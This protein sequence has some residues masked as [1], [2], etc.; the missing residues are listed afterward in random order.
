MTSRW[1]PTLSSDRLLLR[2]IA[3][4]DFEPLFKAASDPLIWEQHSEKTRF[5]R[6][7][8][9]KFFQGALE[10]GGGLVAI[11]PKSGR[12]IGSSRY[13]DWNKADE[14]VVIGYSFLERAQWG[15]GINAEMKRLMLTHAFQWAKTVW[16]HVSPENKRSQLALGKIGATLDRQEDVLVGGVMSPRMIYRVDGKS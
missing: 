9:Q 3:I 15:T 13:Y 2:P 8:F 14:S 1:Q 12:I 7:V 5:E 4:S 16:F 10:C 11:E 6:S